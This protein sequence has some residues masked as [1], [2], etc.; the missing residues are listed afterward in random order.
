MKVQETP[1][2][3][4][5]PEDHGR[6]MSLEEFARAT[7]REG[8]LYELAKGVVIV[9][10]V[11]GLS[12]SRIVREVERQFTAYD[13]DHPEVI[14]HIAAG[15]DCAIRMPAMRSERHPDRAIYL[16]PPPADENPWDLWTPEI[17]VEVVSRGQ[18][19]RD[20]GEKRQE[21]LV[22]GVREYWI[23]DPYRR[24]VLV[25]RRRGDDWTEEEVLA[26]GKVATRLLPGFELDTAR[27]FALLDKP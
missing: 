19:E 17:V 23:V 4:L 8:S 3:L 12:H 9:V 1:A 27:L 26:G 2:L 15:S 20:Y 21:Y 14:R 10:D 5:G 25:L 24:T 16:T 6:R 13:L 22:A 18:E 11:P 7:G